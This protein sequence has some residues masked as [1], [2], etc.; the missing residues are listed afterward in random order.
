MSFKQNIIFPQKITPLSQHSFP[1][2]SKT[3]HLPKSAF[4]SKL[5]I[6]FDNFDETS[7]AKYMILNILCG[8]NF[9]KL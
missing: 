9:D 1:T 2:P 7:L 4:N 8:L 3:L 5:F 6:D